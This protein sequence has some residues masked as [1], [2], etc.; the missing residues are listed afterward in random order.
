MF[1]YLGH[2]CTALEINFDQLYGIDNVLLPGGEET[3]QILI[4]LEA[5]LDGGGGGEGLLFP[6]LDGITCC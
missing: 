6:E 3:P 4:V 5:V 2:D 1:T